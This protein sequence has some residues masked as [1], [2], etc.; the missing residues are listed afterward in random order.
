MTQRRD[1]L[2][3][4]T[5]H[6]LVERARW[7]VRVR[8]T[9]IASVFV[10][11][12][13]AVGSVVVVAM[14]SHT[15]SH[16]LIDSAQQDAAAID[17][18]LK[19][20]VSPAATATTGRNDVVVQLLG[21]DGKVV[22]SDRPVRLTVPLRTTPGVTESAV[23]P[24]LA[25]TFTVVARRSTGNERVALIIVGRSTEQRNETRAEAAGILAVAVPLVVLVLSLILWI[26]IGRALRPVDV[27]REEASAITAAQL[28]RRLAVPPGD[29]EIPR[30]AL[31]LNEMLDR[32]DEGQ[33]L[34][35]QFVS[36]ASHELRSPLAVI[37]QAAEIAEAY[38]DRVG[39][40]S[41][42]QDVLA[43][44]ERLEALVTSLLLLA[45]LEG[46][47]L[48]TGETVDLD[49]VV[50]TEVARARERG[51]VEIDAHGVGAGRTR[52]SAV[53]LGQVVRNLLDN[54]CRHAVS[55][56]TVSLEEDDAGDAVELEVTDDGG[57]IAPDDRARV[58]DRFVRLDDAR[59]R[60]EG[61]SGLGL[62]IVRKIV[63]ACGGSVRIDEAPSG[64]ARFTVRLPRV[65]D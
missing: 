44:S 59:A 11:L 28:R 13:T 21:P 65:A 26:S 32:I 3:R 16:S 62:A 46:E 14:I 63:D 36:D 50:L 5:A 18:Q 55:T 43:E 52:G 37:R 8:V 23:V 39:P 47:D 29:D 48:G 1:R 4:L 17:A 58:F 27:M 56:V 6:A 60:D 30:L 64:G 61:G 7:S 10:L 24:G 57:G 19:R 35:R 31:T 42:A 53:L 54:A 38:P 12:V 15:I 40:E 41:L 45:R 22:A 2:A 33:R 34:Q 49:D 20:G 51:P 25:D 9:T